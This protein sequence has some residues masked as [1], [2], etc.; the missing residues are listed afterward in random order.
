MRQS[1]FN[2]KKL[3]R[4]IIPPATLVLL[5]IIVFFKD[6][7]TYI[8]GL[9]F[10]VIFIAIPIKLFFSSSRKQKYLQYDIKTVDEMTGVEFEKFLMYHFKSKG[11]AVDTTPKSGDFGADLILRKNGIRTVVQ[12]K[13]HSKNVGVKAIQEAIAAKGFYHADKAIVATNSKFT[14]NARQLALTSDIR[15]ID[16]EKLIEFMSA[17]STN[18]CPECGSMLIFNKHIDTSYYHCSNPNCDYKNEI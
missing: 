15:L 11:Y 2:T 16:R 13:R 12:A 9:A 17:N 8:Y 3:S 5:I 7:A 18:I 14:K 6:A 4:L 10:I 1:A